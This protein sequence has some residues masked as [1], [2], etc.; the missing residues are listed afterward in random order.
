MPSFEVWDE[1]KV[2][3]EREGEKEESGRR[4]VEIEVEEREGVGI[5]V[6]EREESGRRGVGGV[7]AGSKR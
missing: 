6:E 4:G 3:L 7:G 2:E 1:E 5:E